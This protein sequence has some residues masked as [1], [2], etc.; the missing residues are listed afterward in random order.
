MESLYKACSLCIMLHAEKKY[1]Y[2]GISAEN[3]EDHWIPPGAGITC[4]CEFFHWL[5][6]LRAS[7]RAS[8]ALKNWDISPLPSH[9]SL[10]SWNSVEKFSHIIFHGIRPIE[11]LTIGPVDS[12][13]ICLGH[14]WPVTTSLQSQH[15]YIGSICPFAEFCGSN[16]HIIMW[17]LCLVCFLSCLDEIQV[18][19]LLKSAHKWILHAS[20]TQNHTTP[21]SVSVS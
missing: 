18:Q 21:F 13:T 6:K 3:R 19:I 10:N 9:N 5:T 14:L 11:L 7:A 12:S 16:L 8:R 20:L 2:M 15:F 4:H 17:T 1:L